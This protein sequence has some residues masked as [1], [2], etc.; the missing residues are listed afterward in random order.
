M[1]MYILNHLFQGHFD[2]TRFVRNLSGVHA[3]IDCRSDAKYLIDVGESGNLQERLNSHEREQ[4]WKRHCLGP[5]KV[6]V[7]Y[8]NRARRK[9]IADDIRARLNPP[10]G[11]R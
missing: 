2:S 11:V 6:A 3:I 5:F 8:A 1:T 10:C 7:L 9:M 4:C